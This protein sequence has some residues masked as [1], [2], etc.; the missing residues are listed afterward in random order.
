M[1][2]PL[3]FDRY[4]HGCEVVI[5]IVLKIPIYIEPIVI[6]KAM[7]CHGQKHPDKV[8]LEFKTSASEPAALKDDIQVATSSNANV[9]SRFRWPRP[10]KG[11]LFGSGILLAMLSAT[12]LR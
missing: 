6:E 12:Y 2:T 4:P 5:P 9:L 10:W 11:L 3:D 7:A 8:S 1:S